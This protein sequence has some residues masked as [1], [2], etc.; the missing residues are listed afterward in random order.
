M[1]ADGPHGEPP[2]ALAAAGI[3]AD[4]IEPRRHWP[5]RRIALLV[6]IGLV[7]VVGLLAVRYGPYVD[8]LHQL[9]GAADD[10]LAQLQ[11]LGPGQLDAATARDLRTSVA[12]LD[13]RVQ[14]FREL[15][16]TDPLV[17]GARALPVIGEQV[18]AADSL[19]AAADSGIAAADTAMDVVDR[20]VAIRRPDGDTS[21]TDPSLLTQLV[22]LMVDSTADMDH[23]GASLAATQQALAAIPDNALPQIRGIRD[24][25]AARL[26]RD[27]PLLDDYRRLDD[28]LPDMLGWREPRR[29]LVLA[30]DPAE[31]RPTGGYIGTIGVVEF[32]QGALTSHAFQDVYSLDLKPGLPYVEPPPALRD[33]L[34]GDQPWLLADSNWSPDFPTA[35]RQALSAYTAES[36]DSDIDGVIGLTTFAL[37][38]ILQVTGPVDLPEHDVTVKAG[39]VTLTILGE[40]RTPAAAGQDRKGIIDELAATLLQRLMALPADEWTA[41]AQALADAGSDRLVQVWARDPAAEGFVSASPWAGDVRHDPGDYLYIVQSNMAPTSKYDLVVHRQ[42]DLDVTLA[43][44]GSASHRVGMAWQNDAALPGEPYAAIRSYSTNKDGLY[45]AYIRALVPA[46]SRLGSAQGHSRVPV[47]GSEETGIESGRAVFG[48]YLLMPPGPSDLAYE[49]TTPN[50]VTVDDQGIREYR[51]TV[52]RQPGAPPD[53]L[54]V[55]VALPAGA[56]VLDVSPAGPVADGQVSVT[57]SDLRDVDLV[58]HYRMP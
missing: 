21:T 28:V 1:T 34:L 40:T 32:R 54:T 13:A 52:Q 36:G 12:D 55:R 42:T 8:R 43:A 29:Y 57:S 26:D 11:A 39:D 20:F 7:A 30:Q 53:A 41:M 10:L 31:L 33:H 37:D 38:R 15:L 2:P 49:W 50:T 4:P 44:D 56:T 58:I 51:L 18:A 17:G 19:V 47:S 23:I 5:R 25:L 24:R 48:N 16:G 22:G 3:G 45:G 14:P 6:L 9:Q 27:L 35:A 46:G